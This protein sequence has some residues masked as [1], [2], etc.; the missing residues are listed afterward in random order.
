MRFAVFHV[1]MEE[2][3]LQS[4]IE[5]LHIDPPDDAFAGE[6]YQDISQDISQDFGGGKL[7]CDFLLVLDSLKDTKNPNLRFWRS[8]SKIGG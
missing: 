5:L 3:E 8:G 6:F 1:E 2:S 7:S 4:Q